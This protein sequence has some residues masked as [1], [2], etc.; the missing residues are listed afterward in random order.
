MS[1]AA[2]DGF[3]LILSDCTDILNEECHASVKV[4]FHLSL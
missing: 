4:R 3:K 1:A 2:A